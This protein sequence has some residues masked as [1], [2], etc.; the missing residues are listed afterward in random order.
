MSPNAEIRQRIVDNMKNAEA[1]AIEHSDDTKA[2]V[3]HL[4]NRD[5]YVALLAEADGHD[6]EGA[7]LADGMLADIGVELVA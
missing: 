4:K 1:L 7:T 5:R 3:Q 6:I 2:C